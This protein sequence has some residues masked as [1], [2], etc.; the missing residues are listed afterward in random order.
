M[1]TEVEQ[2]VEQPVEGNEDHSV[3]SDA[4]FEAG[5][6]AA[7]GEEPPVATEEP[8]EEN[9]EPEP[10]P[11]PEP[12]PEPEPEPDPVQML[13]EEINNL[14]NQL[15]HQNDK[16]FGKLGEA[17]REL[18]NLKQSR[19]GGEITEEDIQDL[20]SDYPELRGESLKLANI[21]AKKLLG[22]SAKPQEPAAP[23][24][25][26]FDPAEVERIAAQRASE[27][28]EAV[29]KQ[30]ALER[31]EDQHADWKEVIKDQKWGQ[32][33]SKQPPEIQEQAANSWDVRFVTK[34][35]SDYKASL[36]RKETSKKRLESAVTP[37]GVATDGPP[38]T[39][40]ADEFM[41]GFKSVAS[42]RL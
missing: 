41:A 42:R 22:V 18:Q 10:E 20:Y 35:L 29:R 32:W 25:Q 12:Q 5:F 30:M 9:N 2:A 37:Q 34:L 4:D 28:A 36:T 8:P 21:V 33:I 13:K 31:L 39:T 38:A 40:E 19:Q 7:R 23:M 14:K 6:A 16:V 3:V 26:A 1:T 15:Q 11:E 17:F 27:A 24:S